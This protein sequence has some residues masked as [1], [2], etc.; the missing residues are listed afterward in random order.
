MYERQ[1]ERDIFFSFL[2]PYDY[3][4][5]RRS[6]FR[7]LPYS[8][9]IPLP[10]PKGG[11]K[12]VRLPGFSVWFDDVDVSGNWTCFLDSRSA[13]GLFSDKGGLWHAVGL[14][15]GVA[16]V[17]LFV[18]PFRELRHDV[19]AVAVGRWVEYFTTGTFKEKHRMK[20]KGNISRVTR[21]FTRKFHVKP[22]NEES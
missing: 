9:Y 15:V 18:V 12:R 5:A 11:W 3:R 7:S 13:L 8:P 14:W 6:I 17:S 21:D 20:W 2:L 10:L 4:L 1:K 16:L 19:V 22:A